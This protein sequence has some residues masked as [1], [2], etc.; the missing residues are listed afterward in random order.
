MR[1]ILSAGNE[2]GC[3]N[4]TRAPSTQVIGLGNANLLS[5]C[6][7]GENLHADPE[8]PFR[9]HQSAFLS[10]AKTGSG[11]HTVFCL[12]WMTLLNNDSAARLTY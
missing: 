4:H 8:K 6:E 11:S 10:F 9:S 2:V 5:R 7:A 3:H 12:G 1:E